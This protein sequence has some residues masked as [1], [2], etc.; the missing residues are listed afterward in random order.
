M[1]L[2]FSIF[3]RWTLPSTKWSSLEFGG[4]GALPQIDPRHTESNRTPNAELA[5]RPC[6]RIPLRPLKHCQ[7]PCV[8]HA[9]HAQRGHSPRG[10]HRFSVDKAFTW[11]ESIV[12]T[13]EAELQ[14]QIV[15]SHFRVDQLS[16]NLHSE[17][18]YA[19]WGSKQQ[20]FLV[21]I[22]LSAPQV[23]WR[24]GL[25]PSH[26]ILFIVIRLYSIVEYD[27]ISRRQ[28]SKRLF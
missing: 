5:I 6:D 16:T 26:R 3:L 14:H 11:I 13:Q 19:Y 25:G 9:K 7:L 4:L 27:F 20:G 21:E 18:V 10:V 28:S 23:L 1:R 8:G 22:G 12:T 17:R 15:W 2:C 24:R